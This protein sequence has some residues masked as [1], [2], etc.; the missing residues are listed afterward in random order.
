MST[1]NGWD[2]YIWQ[3]QNAYSTKKNQYLKMNVSEHAAIIGNDGSIW[4]CTKDFP[5]LT[6]YECEFENADGEMQTVKVNELAIAKA[7]CSGNRTPSAAGIRIGG[8]K[9][10]MTSHDESAFLA[11]LTRIGGGGA[12]IMK[13][14]N[15][16][17][18]SMFNKENVMSNNAP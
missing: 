16:I 15:A 13:T 6:E 8:M 5:E 2:S 1:S 17:V 4:A 10:V 18:I 11:N 9:F 7:V 14:K 12:C 3:V